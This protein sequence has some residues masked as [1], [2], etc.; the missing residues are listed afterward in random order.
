MP[1][2]PLHRAADLNGTKDDEAAVAE[3]LVKLLVAHGAYVEARLWC[4][5]IGGCSWLAG[6]REAEGGD[7]SRGGDL[8]GEGDRRAEAAALGG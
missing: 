1:A 8:A 6:G 7:A 5:G 2:P 3:D 4:P